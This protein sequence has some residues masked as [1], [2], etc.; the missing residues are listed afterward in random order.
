MFI[1][2]YIDAYV[3][4]NVHNYMSLF[5]SIYIYIIIY[6]CIYIERHYCSTN[7]LIICAV[8]HCVALKNNYDI[9]LYMICLYLFYHHCFCSYSIVYQICWNHSS[10]WSLTPW[11]KTFP[12]PSCRVS[13]TKLQW[14]R[15]APL[16]FG[17][18]RKPRTHHAT[19]WA[20]HWA[21]CLGEKPDG[22][23]VPELV[24]KVD[25]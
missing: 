1:D 20:R 13:G 18:Q 3:Y 8:N 21:T 16:A 24:S 23:V 9:Y 22:R 19:R 7:T 4:M 11:P 5:L 2:N 6:I 15:C 12:I 25:S 10:A 17:A 14:L